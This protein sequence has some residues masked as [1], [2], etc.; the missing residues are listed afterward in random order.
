MQRTHRWTWALREQQW[1]GFGQERR[2]GLRLCPYNCH[3][4]SRPAHPFPLQNFGTARRRVKLSISPLGQGCSEDS[5]S[6]YSA[7]KSHLPKTPKTPLLPID[8]FLSHFLAEE[9]YSKILHCSARA[10]SL[11]SIIRQSGCKASLCFMHGETESQKSQEDSFS[12]GAHWGQNRLVLGATGLLKDAHAAEPG[13]IDLAEDRTSRLGLSTVLGGEPLVKVEF[14]GVPESRGGGR[15]RYGTRGQAHLLLAA[16]T[17]CPGSLTCRRA[18]HRWR[19]REGPQ[20]AASAA[21]TPSSGRCSAG[22][23]TASPR[24][25]S[26]PSG[27]GRTSRVRVRCVGSGQGHTLLLRNTWTK[28]SWLETKK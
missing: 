14:W 9:K 16:S 25:T 26:F 1:H 15:Q 11:H 7:P 18:S 2:D 21:G 20:R 3:Y 23:R 5:S 12:P 24:K 27:P 10:T 4:G 8:Y 17:G 13:Q 28:K 19:G 6:L 22:S